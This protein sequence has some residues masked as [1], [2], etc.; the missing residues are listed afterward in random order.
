MTITHLN[1]FGDVRI[2]DCEVIVIVTFRQPFLLLLLRSY[3]V[4][5]TVKL[6][7]IKLH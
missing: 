3:C 5:N 6:N 1:Y 7:T 2:I 4:V